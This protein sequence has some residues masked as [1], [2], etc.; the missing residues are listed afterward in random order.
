MNILIPMAGNGRRFVEAGY[1]PP[2]P[3][4]SVGGKSMIRRVVEN[5]GGPSQ[6][7]VFVVQKNH[8]I[9]WGIDDYLRELC[10]DCRVV[11]VDGPTEGAA[12][13]ALLAGMFIDNNES[14]L[15]ANAD[16]IV[17]DFWMPQ[18]HFMP[19][20]A[21][22]TFQSEDPKW[23]YAAV[24]EGWITAI[25]EKQVISDRATCGIYWYRRGS[26]FVHYAKQMIKK[27]L[28]VNGEFYIAPVY[29]QMILDGGTVV[30]IPVSGMI[31]LGTPEDLKAYEDAH[32][33]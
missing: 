25:A 8:V 16:Q 26:E 21:I 2:K 14:L 11:M 18:E 22:Y 13:T 27:N 7:Y 6:S 24:H 20:G 31:G 12:C 1:G 5:L 33:T 9:G 17:S 3:L 15:I 28:R 30:E 19:A 10:P 4:I 23:S 32:R 29:N